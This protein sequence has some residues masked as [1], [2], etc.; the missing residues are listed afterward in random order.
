MHVKMNWEGPPLSL[1]LTFEVEP[2]FVYPN[3][4]VNQSRVLLVYDCACTCVCVRTVWTSKVV[5]EYSLPLGSFGRKTVVCLLKIIQVF[6]EK[7]K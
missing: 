4:G 2:T 5:M 7:I 6:L 3:S 1:P